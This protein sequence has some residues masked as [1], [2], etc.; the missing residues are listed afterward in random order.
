MTQR[1]VL[2]VDDDPVIR[3]TVAEFLEVVGHPVETAANGVEALECVEHHRPSLVILDMHMPVMDGWG[4]AR[5]LHRRGFDPPILVITAT[6]SSHSQVAA[7]VGAAASLPKP[8]D[9][10]DLVEA[11]E[12]LC[13]P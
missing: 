13:V 9:L 7:E 2:D 1:P 6:S 11:V 8:F 12:T 10:A 4:F 3:D 5:E